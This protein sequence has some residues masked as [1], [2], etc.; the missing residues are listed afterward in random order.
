[1][2]GETLPQFLEQTRGRGSNER[3]LGRD[4]I[5]MP[6]CGY[7]QRNAFARDRRKFAP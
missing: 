7:D 4:E 3:N 2:R 6:G 1:M 5:P